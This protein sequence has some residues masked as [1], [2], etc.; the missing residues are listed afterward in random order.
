MAKKG[1]GQLFLGLLLLTLGAALLVARLQLVGM[2]PAILMALGVAF[3]LYGVFSRRL[4]PLVPGCLLLGLG[5]GMFLGDRGL[6]SLGV[7]K[8]N[9]VGLGAGFV[10]IFLLALLL[11]LGTQFWA[12]VVGCV[13]LAVAALPQLKHLLQPEVVVALR[14]YWPVVL[15]AMGLYLLARELLR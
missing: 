4:S 8:W 10:L 12:L 15:V 2:G 11:G 14:T 7:V 9:L 6:A 3:S 13:L 5:A 1:G